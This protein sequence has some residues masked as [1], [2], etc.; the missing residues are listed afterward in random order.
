MKVRKGE[1]V[2]AIS[3]KDLPMYR[4]GGWKVVQEPTP[5]QIARYNENARLKRMKRKEEEDVEQP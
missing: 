5:E 3:P 1:V 2:I 4:K